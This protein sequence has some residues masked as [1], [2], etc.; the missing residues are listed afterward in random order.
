MLYFPQL[1][2]GASGQYPMV[3]KRTIRTVENTGIDAHSLKLGD[4]GGG[5]TLWELHYLGLTDV[6]WRAIAD[7]FEATEGRLR[8]FT[9]L[10]P[11]DN[12]LTHT[13]DL[14]AAE[15]EPD[16]LLRLTPAVP[17]PHGTSLATRA[18]NTAQIPQRILQYVEIPANFHYC[19]SV[20]ARSGQVATVRLER[21]S[22][23]RWDS[24]ARVITPNWR[25][26]VSSGN[27]G[28]AEVGVSV[29]VELEPGATVELF[30]FQL[31]PQP[32]ASKYKATKSR[33]GVYRNVRFAEDTLRLTTEGPQNTATVVRIVS[34]RRD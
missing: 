21:S 22:D 27:L 10:D 19:F 23:S 24:T 11:A 17:D 7:L 2:T 26:L 14:T 1:Q 15:W 20:Y 13:D 9:F 5:F 18:T 3:R 30:G 12:L 8:S 29:G 6:E 16:A 34:M 31:E 32:A 33:S 4:P 28:A 25:R